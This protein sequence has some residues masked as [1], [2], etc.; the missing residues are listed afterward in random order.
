M[1]IS[2]EELRDVYPDFIES[3]KLAVKRGICKSL[4]EIPGRY[5][6]D[7]PDYADL[8]EKVVALYH[9]ME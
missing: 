1:D 4:D 5:L 9:S 6:E 2:D 7:E 3:M 8:L